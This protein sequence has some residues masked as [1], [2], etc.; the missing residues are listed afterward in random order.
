[1][2]RCHGKDVRPNE[3]FERVAGNCVWVMLVTQ[4]ARPQTL[5]TPRGQP[6]VG[7][8]VGATRSRKGYRLWSDRCGTVAKKKK[9]KK[10]GGCPLIILYDSGCQSICNQY[11][12]SNNNVMYY[13]LFFKPFKTIIW[14]KMIYALQ[15][16]N[17]LALISRG[18]SWVSMKIGGCKF[19]DG[20]TRG[21]PL[22]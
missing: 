16:I 13:I 20:K 2:G 15:N 11:S 7:A 6:D 10:G 9:K 4:Y 14:Q 3:R 22:S 17:H 1:M 21:C 19:I 8:G 18:C 5:P 12:K